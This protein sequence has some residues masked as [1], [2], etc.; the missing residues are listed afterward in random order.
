MKRRMFHARPA[1]LAMTGAAGLLIS[2]SLTLSNAPDAKAG[3]LACARLADPAAR[4]ACF[5]QEF[6]DA[7]LHPPQTETGLWRLESTPS[8]IAGRTDHS[9]SLASQSV[10]QCRFAE[11]RPVQLRIRCIANVTSVSLETGCYM[12]SAQ[13][14]DDGDVSIQL[15]DGEARRIRMSSG[16]DGRSLGLWSG[17][18]AI[19]L[20]RELL[21]KSA[22]SVRMT[23]YAD[24]PVSAVFDLRGIDQAISAARTECGW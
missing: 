9:I 24:D 17:T 4:L 11:P 13:Y 22:L 5:D 10:I 1:I 20:V 23:P 8:V 7:M 2:L 3:P 15:D 18:A 19:P 12:A 16:A 6:P 14:R 21:G